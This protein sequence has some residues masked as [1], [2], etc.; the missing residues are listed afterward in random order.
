MRIRRNTLLVVGGISSLTGILGSTMYLSFRPLTEV[1]TEAADESDFM[2]LE[3]DISYGSHLESF[4]DAW[5][6]QKRVGTILGP[7][8]YND[9]EIITTD[10]TWFTVVYN[11]EGDWAHDKEQ[12]EKTANTH[13]IILERSG[14]ED[15]ILTK[16]LPDTPGMYSIVEADS[17][18]FLNVLCND[19]LEDRDRPDKDFCAEWVKGRLKGKPY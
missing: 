19:I 18:L 9:L 16:I 12:A 11:R 7:D 15:N 8:V 2:G 5:Q 17:P 3:L 6:L 14:G 1:A 10:Q 4:S 13:R